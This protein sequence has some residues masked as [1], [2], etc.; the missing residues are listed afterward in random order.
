M[1]KG[2]TFERD[3]SRLLSQWWS[4]DPDCDDLFWRTAGSGARATV[5][6]KKNKST[7]GHAGD[8]GA[9]DPIGKPLMDFI[10][11]ELK[12]GYWRVTI[13]DLLDKPGKV[14]QEFERWIQKAERSKENAGSYSWIIVHKRDRREPVVIFPD[15]LL[16]IYHEDF[17]M[18]NPYFSLMVEVSGKSYNLVGVTLTY[19]LDF[20]KPEMIRKFVER[21]KRKEAS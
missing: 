12:R 4:N 13:A 15:D 8:I 19:F 3:F 17:P 10:T 5:R 1:A 11:I 6:G 18:K 21:I 7:R 9:T 20:F 14:E 16:R 2:Q